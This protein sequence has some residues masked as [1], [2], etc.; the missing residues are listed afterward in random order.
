[1]E[2][3]GGKGNFLGFEFSVGGRNLVLVVVVE[4]RT[5]YNM[6]V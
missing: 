2:T 5:L 1:V 4:H 6:N 3:E